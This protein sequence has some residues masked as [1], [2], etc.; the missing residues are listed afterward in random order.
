MRLRT[1]FS[2]LLLGAT[3]AYSGIA[4]A[5]GKTSKL[6]SGSRVCAI[7]NAPAPTESA[8]VGTPALT[9]EE[10]KNILSNDGT[11]VKPQLKVGTVGMEVCV[12]G[13]K[14]CVPCTPGSTYTLP[15]STG[16]KGDD[17]LITF[18]CPDQTPVAGKPSCASKFNGNG[19]CL[20]N[21]IGYYA[22]GLTEWVGG[23]CTGKYTACYNT[24]GVKPFATAD[25][26]AAAQKRIDE[27]GQKVSE[28]SE[29]VADAAARL[30]NAG[31]KGVPLEKALADAQLLDVDKFFVSLGGENCKEDYARVQGLVTEARN[32]RDAR[33][34]AAN[35]LTA[36]LGKVPAQEGEIPAGRALLD[37]ANQ[38]VVPAC[39]AESTTLKDKNVKY[40]EA[41][42][43][44]KS[45]VDFLK[46]HGCNY[47]APVEKKQG[48]EYTVLV[49]YAHD[50][51]HGA[52]AP[53]FQAELR[54]SADVL[55]GIL[56]LGGYLNGGFSSATM[57]S[58]AT[59]DLGFAQQL[60]ESEHN[61]KRFLGAGGLLEW[62]TLP[63]D[64][65]NL[66]A[67][68]GAAWKRD[69][70][71]RTTT[72][73]GKSNRVD[74]VEN[75]VVGEFGLGITTGYGPEGGMWRW[76]IGPQAVVDTDGHYRVIG[77]TGFTFK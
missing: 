1:V 18:V 13:Q 74:A 28:V 21:N 40:E 63:G 19:S 36:C 60:T 41:V 72:V 12:P 73:A 62:K 22:F 38:G 56:W 50:L 76:R 49:G 24:A 25:S 64:Y 66:D 58:S 15:T 30:N 42:S 32:T 31:G 8:P 75:R 33:D 9:P 47:K 6:Y 77:S 52:S 69:Y 53:A 44:L 14:N 3:L 65:L 43:A 59:E 34:G 35:D 5:E 57:N 29:K 55:R 16:G 4:S 61:V 37:Y 48:V 67:M 27:V 51:G 20:D 17:D 39:P 68:I 71:E 11:C 46:E 54:V 2:G 23:L 7:S 10:L 45:A 70:L 26:L